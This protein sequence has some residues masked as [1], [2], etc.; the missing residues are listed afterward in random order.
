MIAEGIL[1]SLAATA[2]DLL[3]GYMLLGVERGLAL[4]FCSMRNTMPVSIRKMDS[5]WKLQGSI[6]R[7]DIF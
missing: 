3:K 5:A 6:I 4:R 1:S 2:R 7:L